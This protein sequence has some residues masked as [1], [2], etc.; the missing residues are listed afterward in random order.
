MTTLDVGRT[1]D[2]ANATPER[3]P[4]TAMDVVRRLRL[5]RW[6]PFRVGVAVL[7]LVNTF[8]R[9]WTLSRWS[10]FQDDWLYLTRSHETDL[11][12]YL[13]QNYNGHI[14]PGDFL[15]AWT[16]SRLAPLDY[17][18]AAG[19]VVI[20]SAACTVVWAATLRT[21]FGDRLRLLV[22]LVI[23]TLSPILLPISIWW[24]AAIQIYPLQLSMGLAILFLARWLRIGGRANL[25]GLTASYVMGLFFWEKALL[26]L[27]PLVFITLFLG[28]GSWR[29][30]LRQVRA[31]VAI[32]FA[33]TIV[34][35]PLYLLGTR[36]PGGVAG[37]KTEL[38]QHRSVGQSLSFYVTGLLDLGLPT[39]AGGPWGGLPNLLSV[40]SPVPAT[41]WLPMLALLV[42]LSAVVVTY[43]RRG[44]LTIAMV[45]CYAGLS[46][47]LLLTSSRYDNIGDYAV[48]DARY[49]ADILP[50]A[51]LGL[52]FCMAQTRIESEHG[53]VP[54]RVTL[55][56]AARR[57]STAM[58]GALIAALSLSTLYG[59][60]AS[61]QRL[62]PQSPK[63]WVDSLISDAR[64]AKTASVFDTFPPN[65]V[66]ASFFF[67]QDAHISRLLLPLRLSLAFNQPAPQML[68][69]SDSGQLKEVDIGDVSHSVK[70][71]IQ[72]CGYL[73]K[74]LENTYV[75]ISKRM[76]NWGWG[77][78]LD[79][80]SQYG[81]T[82]MVRTDTGTQEVPIPAGIGKMQFYR[83]DSVSAVGLR[84][85]D[86]SGQVCVSKLTI[87]PISIS[88]RSPFSRPAH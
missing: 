38:F 75:P 59:N 51:I 49:A 48:R 72:K 30:R 86:A 83:T 57:H 14:M 15:L 21:I 17:T 82:M 3:K 20:S 42:T 74:P 64:R 29:M 78:Q 80:Y 25:I 31:P 47:G 11:L 67:P 52:A 85:A 84:M 70:A 77:Y 39:L 43:R 41:R 24:A 46:W 8:W 88:D 62:E 2:P 32:L 66:I 61:W 45:A 4:G 40:Y 69:V 34:Y 87:G 28:E 55:P 1:V 76:F 50:V 79:Y 56:A 58:V 22:P 13:T 53:I 7:I 10:W 18:L 36:I 12:H 19:F 54:W 73:V 81:G 33:I 6:N 23:L 71:P 9:S 26:I 16:I 63:P 68:A 27:I 44:W 37:F 60:G 35:V 65:Q 5:W